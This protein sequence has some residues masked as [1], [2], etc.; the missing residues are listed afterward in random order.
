MVV[1]YIAPNRNVLSAGVDQSREPCD[2]DQLENEAF[3]PELST[4]SIKK[5]RHTAVYQKKGVN[6]TLVDWV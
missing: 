3:K 2:S 5:L 6:L 1:S 4:Y